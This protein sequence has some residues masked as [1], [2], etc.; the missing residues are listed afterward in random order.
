MQR[1]PDECITIIINN[2]MHTLEEI[3]II[4][5]NVCFISNVI[6]CFKDMCASVN[7]K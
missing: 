2:N 1:N 6:V 4:T 7:M 3:Y 5:V